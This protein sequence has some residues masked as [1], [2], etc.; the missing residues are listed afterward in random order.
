MEKL[1]NQK[2]T[3]PKHAL[4]SR[5]KSSSS[6]FLF[7]FIFLHFVVILVLNKVARQVE[8]MNTAITKVTRKHHNIVPKHAQRKSSRDNV[9]ACLH[10]F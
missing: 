2:F 6:S 4:Q 8:V 1:P 5:N 9:I 10:I 3:N 7:Y